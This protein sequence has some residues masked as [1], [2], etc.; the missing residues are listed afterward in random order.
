MRPAGILIRPARLYIYNKHVLCLRFNLLRTE[1]EAQQQ[2]NVESR[3]IFYSGIILC[4][5][6]KI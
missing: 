3:Y 5:R 4:D 6:N 1:S 2:L